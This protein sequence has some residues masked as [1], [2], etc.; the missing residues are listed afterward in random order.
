MA[1]PHTGMSWPVRL[2]ATLC[3]VGII[4]AIGAIGV[5]LYV[6]L[7]FGAM[8]YVDVAQVPSRPAAIVFGAGLSRTGGLSPI[9]ADR[10]NAAYELYR[11]GKVDKLLL[12]GDN[13]FEWYNEPGSMAE[14]LLERGVPRDDLVLDYA[15]RRT[16]DS[17]YRAR[18]IFGLD[19]AILVT[20]NFHLDR[21]LFTCRGLGID[22]V[23]FAADRRHTNPFN[24]LR[25][26]PATAAAWW[27]IQ[28]RR[29]L[30]VMGEV[31]PVDWDA[32]Q[33]R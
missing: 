7:T 5:R 12:S 10:V 6:D 14:Y 19:R 11:A 4:L 16:Y 3:G 22:A 9:L 13:R 23:G 31:V 17:C 32:F 29:P 25:E 18:H 2:M 24:W 28:V 15:G 1:A 27:D 20:Q 8:I 26:I 21:A 33:R 30:P